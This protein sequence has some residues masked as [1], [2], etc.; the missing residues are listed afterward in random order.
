MFDPLPAVNFSEGYPSALVVRLLKDL[1]VMC[2]VI[3]S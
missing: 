3:G 1:G 2:S